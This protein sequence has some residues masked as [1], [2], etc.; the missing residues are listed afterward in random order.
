MLS[1]RALA[2][3][4]FS[5]SSK[6]VDKYCKLAE[7]RN[8]EHAVVKAQGV[9][10]KVSGIGA[11]TTSL[12]SAFDRIVIK[13]LFAS[14]QAE[15]E[16][17]G[18]AKIG[19]VEN[20]KAAG[21]L[22]ENIILETQQNSFVTSKTSVARNGGEFMKGLMMFKSDAVQVQGK[23]IN[24]KGKAMAIK[25]RLADESLT[26]GEKTELKKE[27]KKVKKNGRKAIGALLASSVWMLAISHA[28]ALLYN[29]D[30]E[31][32]ENSGLE[33]LGNLLGGLPGIADVYEYF[34]NG[35]DLESM[36]MSAINDLLSASSGVIEYGQKMI[37]GEEDSRDTSSLIKKLLFAA[38]QTS[39]IPIRNV[40]N[41]IYGITRRVN[42]SAAYK[43]DDFF[44]K[45]NYDKDFVEEAKSGKNELAKDILGMAFEENVGEGV[46][47]ETLNE[48]AR[49]A[50]TKYNV[51][52]GGISKSI[53]IDGESYDLTAEE[54]ETVQE[55]YSEVIPELNKLIVSKRYQRLDDKQKQKAIKNLLSR[56]R[57]MGYD[58]VRG[59]RN[60]KTSATSAW[61][62]LASKSTNSTKKKTG[63]VSVKGGY[64]DF[65]KNY[66][67]G[68][69]YS[70]ALSKYFK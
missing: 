22:L 25:K 33:Y 2:R 21:E 34:I 54:R 32:F 40:Y 16:L 63:I 56:Y 23:I 30:E 13:R 39:G 19:S 43:I 28:F 24:E 15:V 10:D 37:S 52:P 6:D 69:G 68:S 7:L 65:N 5:V 61:K 44:K 48:F 12:I 14:C 42:E 38:G 64:F 9:I 50:T 36:E 46:S 58:E 17:Q 51:T 53:T 70:A 18:G 62:A 26:S 1:K 20:K 49:L 59:V 47:E 66:F 57:K 35:Y 27:L 67:G 31:E 29:K 41:F 8:R 3:G 60:P 11:K 45:Q 4:T 55:I